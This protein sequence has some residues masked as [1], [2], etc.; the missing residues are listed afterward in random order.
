MAISLVHKSKGKIVTDNW[1]Y[2]GSSYLDILNL[3]K[4]YNK[5]QK[6]LITE[7][8]NTNSLKQRKIFTEWLEKQRIFFDD[9][10]FWWMNGLS[11]RNNFSSNFFLYICQL[12]AIKDYLSDNPNKNLTIVSENYFLIDFLIHNLKND[13]EVFI[14]NNF[15]INLFLEKI[16]MY[17][18]G[19]KNYAEVIFFFL[20][21]Y[22]FAKK[23]RPK[24]N[25]KP[26]GD[27]FLFHDLI[28]K[29]EFNDNIVQSRY[30]GSYP[31]WLKKN[32]KDVR[33]LPW[34]YKNLKNKNELYIH[35]RKNNSFIPEDWLSLKDYL[36]SLLNSFKS[37]MT[38]NENIIY[39][40]INIKSLTKIQ[41]LLALQNKSAIYFRYFPAF[42]RWAK[43]ITSLIFFDNYQNQSF[44]HPIRFEMKNSSIK[45]KSI[46]YYH[47]LHSKS[48]LPYL[49]VPGEWKSKSKPDYVVCPN[50]LCKKTL[51]DQGIPENK[52]KIIS[53][54]Q[55][56]SFNNINF[57]KEYNKKL[58][59][60][61]SL[62]MESNYE[63]LTKIYRI[64]DY[65][66]NDLGLKIKIRSHPYIKTRD[67]LN[68][69]KWQKLPKSWE[70]SSQDL[71]GD[72][73]ENYC[74]V[75]MHSAVVTDVVIHNN[76]LVVL[77]SELNIGE[78]YLDTLENKF[79]ILNSTLDY[80][81]K[82]KLEEIFVTKI[83]NY[84]NQFS[85]IKDEIDLNIDKD[86]K[87][88]F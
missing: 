29:S 9:S 47:S 39:P 86:Y 71:E 33:T 34:F 60:I 24:F 3:E 73:R 68:N 79:S 35:F 8:I 46:G 1:I 84:K 82:K 57:K 14:P 10:I 41:K 49:S 40:N 58:L 38:L 77:K 21:N 52:I 64:N 80:N 48:Y 66:T 62:F 50:I 88:N 56:E 59:I 7:R 85:Q 67:I 17:T 43:N 65:L 32:N 23:T 4:K 69:L 6:I 78:N 44:E 15:T 61:L 54:L 26:K 18:L 31:K 5:K 19:I 87:F 70:W 51:L 53:D 74:V 76:I 2:F 42:K 11:S 75:T 28:S 72:L 36:R 16:T 83:D 37:S 45:G 25:D 12:C 13:Y 81:L 27:I 55:R 63:L 22:Y 30:F 20:S